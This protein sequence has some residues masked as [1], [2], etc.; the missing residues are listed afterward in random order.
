MKNKDVLLSLPSGASLSLGGRP[1]IMG[2]LNLTPDSFYPGSRLTD[3]KA[4]IETAE[5]MIQEGAELLDLGGESTRPG[6]DYV[7]AEE[8]KRR[9]I[10]VL[11]AL[12]RETNL[13]IS[14]DTRKAA[15]AKA[16]IAAGADIIND[17]TALRDDP[18]LVKVVKD[19]GAGVILM[20]SRGTP[21]TMQQNPFYNDTIREIKEELVLFVSRAEEQGI[22]R[23]KIILDPGIG[24]GKRLQ[25]NLLIL[26]HL[27]DFS[28]LGYPLL[29]G[30]SRKSFLGALTGAEVE[31]RLSGTLAANCF[32][33]L[34]GIDILRVHDVKE[35]AQAVKIFKAILGAQ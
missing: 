26:K 17:V 25:D 18:D 19:S 15:V 4:A 24:F 8:E 31:D 9:V 34:K 33:L 5:R 28:S 11:E 14:V 12:R 29:L 21:K 7:D 16:A 23:E 35:T 30:V 22:K 20:H 10:P 1:L 3:L 13:P 27:E 6:S 2:I 32:A